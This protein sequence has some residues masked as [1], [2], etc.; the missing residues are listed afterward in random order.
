M[1]PSQE[2]V[3]RDMEEIQIINVR[4]SVAYNIF[5]IEILQ[6]SGWTVW[7]F[8]WCTVGLTD[9]YMEEVQI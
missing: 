7:V 8:E 9:K 5:S 3:R 2:S 6:N 4:L 1:A